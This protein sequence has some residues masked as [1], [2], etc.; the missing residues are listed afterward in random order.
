MRCVRTYVRIHAYGYLLSHWLCV[1]CAVCHSLQD[2]CQL[3]E[4]EGVEGITEPA[5]S[6]APRDRSGGGAG[7]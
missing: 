4:A 5:D 7:A 3:R 1:L 6:T 2:L